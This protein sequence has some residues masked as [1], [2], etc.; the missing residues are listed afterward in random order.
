MEA[1][2]AYM[3]AKTKTKAIEIS[4][5]EYIEALV[6]LSGKINIDSDWQKAEEA[7]LN[8]FRLLTE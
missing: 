1:L 3:E 8:E 2:T 4:T 5:L 7:E 6:S